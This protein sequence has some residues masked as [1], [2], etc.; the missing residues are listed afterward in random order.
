MNARTC[1]R[2]CVKVCAAA[3]VAVIA[4][5]AIVITTAF[6]TATSKAGKIAKMRKECVVSATAVDV[7][8]SNV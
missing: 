4:L 8:C 5:W 7:T 6:E 2:I 1:V 3:I